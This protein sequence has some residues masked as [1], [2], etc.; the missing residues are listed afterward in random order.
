MGNEKSQPAGLTIDETPTE[1]TDG[2]SLHGA[3]YAVG[4]VPKISVFVSTCPVSS[5]SSHLEKFTK[6]VMVYRHPCIL[7]YV[8]HWRKG[9]KFHLATEQVQPLAQVLPSQ[10]SLQI[11]VGLQSVLKALVFLHESGTAS[12]NN[13]CRASVYVTQGGSW[14][15]GGLEYLCRFNE[16]SSRYLEETRTRRYD[17]SVA[18]NE[19]ESLPQPVSA[20]DA[21]A[22]GVL[23]SEVLINKNPDEVPGMPDFLELC[24]KQLQS[25]NCEVRPSLS[26][27]LSHPFFSHEFLSIHNFLVDLP[28]KKEE[29]KQDFF[30]NLSQ[31]LNSFPEETVASQLGSLLLSRMV[32]LDSTAQA[33][34][35]PQVFVPRR[36]DSSEN[37]LFTENTFKTHMVPR[38]LPLFCVRDVQIR[39]ILL[40]YFQSYCALFSQV[41]LQTRILPELLVGIKD[42][43]DSVVCSTL[44]ALAELVPVLG[45]AVVIGGKRAKLFADGRPK[46]VKPSTK[47]QQSKDFKEDPSQFLEEGAVEG[48]LPERP[49]P[50]GGEY[51]PTPSPS[52]EEETWPD[53]DYKTNPT[54][55]E[56]SF[57]LTMAEEESKSE[58][59]EMQSAAKD[60]K[61]VKGGINS[62]ELRIKPKV[63][64][65]FEDIFRDM[66][67]VIS[68]PQVV[69]VTE[70]AKVTDKFAPSTDLEADGWGEDFDAWDDIDNDNQISVS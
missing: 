36:E 17:P 7:K 45:G 32:L 58:S 50:D 19:S 65:E 70:A 9:S 54:A 6:N 48:E 24:K 60:K 29:E 57:T 61:D 25:P 3:T 13:V 1:V 11:C 33:F 39:L 38:L 30:R 49:S 56:P 22:F 34:L 41:Q 8:S 2:W 5:E 55:A 46:T 51:V 66:E 23:A 16:M 10:T 62:L 63:K 35:L 31:K 69:H 59:T 28:I 14:K 43:N 53:W 44:R 67:P 47:H 4:S 26:S 42:V 37:G 18:A 68:K 27:L 40:S 64:D 20:V 52:E 12:H 15:L 21:Y